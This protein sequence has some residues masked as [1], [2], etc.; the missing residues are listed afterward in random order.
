MINLD[1]LLKIMVVQNLKS[2]NKTRIRTAH[3][4]HQLL[5]TL[6]LQLLLVKMVLM[7]R[8]DKIISNIVIGKIPIMVKSKYCIR[9]K[10]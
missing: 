1:S 6:F 4:L 8:F 3:I 5:L 2:K 7:L 10:Y 9:I